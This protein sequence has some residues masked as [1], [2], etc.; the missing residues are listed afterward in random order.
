[1]LF[2]IAAFGGVLA[3]W[4]LVLGLLSSWTVGLG[5]ALLLALIIWVID[6]QRAQK[7][8]F[9]L[10]RPDEI[11]P[12]IL[13]GFW[14][15]LVDRTFKALRKE[16][17]RALTSERRL[18]EFLSA[19]QVSPNGVLLLDEQNRIEWANKT[20]SQHFGVDI[21][22]DLLQPIGNLVRSPEFMN[23]LAT[24]D[25]ASRVSFIVAANGSSFIQVSVQMHPYGEGKHLMLSDAQPVTQSE[26][27]R[28]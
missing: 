26:T 9:W 15:E 13:S 23:Y 28:P 4:A 14:G 2:R 10:R 18:A 24:K 27:S 21:K 8:L 3:L 6:S 16:R 12:P 17:T 11:S 20:A 7:A 22:R 25:F 5:S 19:I 1:M